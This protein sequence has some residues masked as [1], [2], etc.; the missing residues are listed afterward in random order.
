[1]V[2]GTLYQNVHLLLSRVKGFNYTKIM[3]IKLVRLGDYVHFYRDNLWFYEVKILG[4]GNYF[5]NREHLKDKKWFGADVEQ[6]L[7]ILSI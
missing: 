3:E 6:Q 7:L 4:T 5:P 1:M 2:C